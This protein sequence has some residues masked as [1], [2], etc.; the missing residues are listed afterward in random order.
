LGVIYKPE[1]D[2]TPKFLRKIRK[3]LDKNYKG[4][5]PYPSELYPDLDIKPFDA[6]EYFP[7]SVMK[8]YE[9]YGGYPNW[10]VE[11]RAAQIKER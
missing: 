9:T 7:P 2:S 10:Y 5:E 8:Y 11:L 6:A 3:I 1:R 4:E